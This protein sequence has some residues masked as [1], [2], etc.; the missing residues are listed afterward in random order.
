MNH[1]AICFSGDLKLVES[2][3]RAD[4]GGI[5]DEGFVIGITPGCLIGAIRSAI[6]DVP[7]IRRMNLK[8]DGIL[9]VAGDVHKQLAAREVT[10]RHIELSEGTGE[11][12]A[13]D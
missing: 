2:P 1:N 8:I 3:C 7:A 12:V 11:F 5:V 9:L 6:D 10:M 4:F 13:V